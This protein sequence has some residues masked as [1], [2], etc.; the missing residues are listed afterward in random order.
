MFQDSIYHAEWECSL[1][2]I[3]L[4]WWVCCVSRSNVKICP[5]GTASVC[6]QVKPEAVWQ[7]NLRVIFCWLRMWTCVVTN[8]C[9]QSTHCSPDGN[10]ESTHPPPEA[11]RNLSAT[12]CSFSHAL[13]FVDADGSA[14]QLSMNKTL[15]YSKLIYIQRERKWIW[16]GFWLPWKQ[17]A[18]LHVMS[19]VNS[20]CCISN[21]GQW[22]AAS[23]Y[24]WLSLRPHS[25]IF[26]CN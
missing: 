25:Y 12:K 18:D 13:M 21:L 15:P 3:S 20:S 5:K 16:I 23:S 26:T 1:P 14:G 7:W 2:A 22:Q 6:M 8:T 9:L 17:I 11:G 4:L 10:L 19:H 24:E